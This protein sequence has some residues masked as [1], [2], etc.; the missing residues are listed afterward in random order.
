[1]T[2]YGLSEVVLHSGG[3]YIWRHTTRTMAASISLEQFYM[4]SQCHYLAPYAST[5]ICSA[6]SFP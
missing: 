4:G 1:M 5:Y 2:S 6:F 3:A